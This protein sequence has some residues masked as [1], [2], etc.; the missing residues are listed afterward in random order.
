MSA[1]SREGAAFWQALDRVS[2]DPIGLPWNYLEFVMLVR[3]EYIAA[4]ASAP[5]HDAVGYPAIE[6]SVADGISELTFSIKQWTMARE[7]GLFAWDG[8]PDN[9]AHARRID[10]LLESRKNVL[11]TLR[12]CGSVT[13]PTDDEICCRFLFKLVACVCTRQCCAAHHG[14]QL[15]F[16]TRLARADHYVRCRRDH[17]ETS[18]PLPAVVH[19]NST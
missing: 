1:A 11:E 6:Q 3:K 4:L 5:A 19:T 13:M 15:V 16:M 2:A 14:R 9:A 7:Q 10:A 8:E 18:A 17:S 12:N